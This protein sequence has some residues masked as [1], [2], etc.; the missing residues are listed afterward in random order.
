MRIKD[1][2]LPLKK[3]DG[4]AVNPHAN[5]RLP[6]HLTTNWSKFTGRYTHTN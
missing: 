5:C 1:V 2:M 4:V 6:I 3:Q